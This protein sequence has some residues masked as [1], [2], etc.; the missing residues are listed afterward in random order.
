MSKTKDVIKTLKDQI[1]TYAVKSL[2][3]SNLK[4]EYSA[5]AEKTNEN[6]S[7]LLTQHENQKQKLDL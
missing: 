5:F 6:I 1:D 2:E 3:V 4:K 7:K